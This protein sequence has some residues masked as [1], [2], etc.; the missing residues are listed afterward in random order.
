M[1]F[2]ARLLQ[3]G[4]PLILAYHSVSDFRRDA[5]AVGST[6]FD[7]QMS[8]LHRRGYRAI[9]LA[10]YAARGFQHASK[11]AI[12]TFDDGYA[13]NFTVALPILRHYGFVA[14]VFLVSDYVGTDRIFPWDVSRM[15]DHSDRSHYRV[16]SWDEVGEMVASGFEVGSHTCTHRELVPL[17]A[18][19][20]WDEIRRSRQILEEKMGQ[21]VVTFSYPRG[22]INT[23]VIRM[24]AQAGYQCGVIT[25]PH[26]GIPFSPYTL[27]RIGVYYPNSQLAFRIKAIPL[28]R[29]NYE[30]LH[31]FRPRLKGQISTRA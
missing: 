31:Y 18:E 11:T 26:A 24:V 19:D 20:R 29:R 16:L 1:R 25:P 2:L 10:D 17:S 13:D 23:Q 7:E 8:W 6:G 14:T 4:E 3:S 22:D 15:K 30:R 5:L 28:V 12:I 27:R 9:T 21:E